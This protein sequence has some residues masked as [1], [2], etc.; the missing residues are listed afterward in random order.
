MAWYNVSAINMP[1]VLIHWSQV[2]LMCINWEMKVFKWS[3]MLNWLCWGLFN[4]ESVSS[5]WKNPCWYSLPQHDTLWQ[6]FLASSAPSGL[7][8]YWMAVFRL[9]SGEKGHYKT[10]Q[11]RGNPFWHI[12]R[13]NALIA[14]QKLPQ[15]LDPG[16]RTRDFRLRAF[17]WWR[18]HDA[19]EWVPVRRMTSAGWHQHD[20]V[21]RVT[22][23]G[24]VA[25]WRDR[26]TSR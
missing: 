3:L 13:S 4:A 12:S 1:W 14:H 11:K 9:I 19:D 18:Q 23:H 16:I 26:V 24:D 7:Q 20:D 6:W 21:S 2:T 15:K 25:G 22:W 8:N 10:A 17:L 5:H